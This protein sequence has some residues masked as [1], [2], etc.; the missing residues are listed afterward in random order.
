MWTGLRAR[1]PIAAIWTVCMTVVLMPWLVMAGAFGALS[2]FQIVPEFRLET[3]ARYII[4]GIYVWIA[5]LVA[6][7]IW[8]A[9]RLRRDFREAATDRF[10]DTQPINWRPIWC[11]FW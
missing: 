8:S 4:T 11:V 5:Y 1:H 3:D 9:R 7:S 6:L 10:S 2:A